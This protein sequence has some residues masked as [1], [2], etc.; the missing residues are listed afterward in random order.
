LKPF[1]SPGVGACYKKCGTDKRCKSKCFGDAVPLEKRQECYKKSFG[2][3]FNAKMKAC[4]AKFLTPEFKTCLAKCGAAGLLE[5][6]DS[7]EDAEELGDAE[8]IHQ[9]HVSSH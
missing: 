7:T 9:S 3:D 2:E 6:D 1:I 8:S 5:E 4:M